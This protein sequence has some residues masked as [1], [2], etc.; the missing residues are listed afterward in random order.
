MS[1]ENIEKRIEFIIEQQAQ[2]TSDMNLLKDSQTQ[3]TARVDRLACQVE[4]L[5]EIQAQAETRLSRV[6]E[7]FVLLVQMARIT[8]ERLDNLSE[9]MGMLTEAQARTD[10]KLADLAEAQTHTDERL[11]T[12]INVIERYIS[13]G[14]N[15]NSQG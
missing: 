15:G 3:L 13:K 12:L 5:A 14:S 10:N 1:N 8:D 11:N 6:E 2:F 7:S 4:A 9:K